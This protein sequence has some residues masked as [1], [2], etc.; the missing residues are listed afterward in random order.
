MNGMFD[1]MHQKARSMVR[2]IQATIFRSFP[3]L[4]LVLTVSSC[5]Q[6]EN[7]PGVEFMPDMYRSPAIEAYMDYHFPD[8][9]MAMHPPE[10]TVPFNPEYMGSAYNPNLPYP[11]PNTTDGYE[12]AGKELRNPIPLTTENL[13]KGEQIFTNYCEHCH[14]EKGEG[15]GAVVENGGHAPPPSF[16]G[17]LSDLPDGKAFH[18]ITYGKG[19]MG[20]HAAQLN[21]KERWLVIHYINDLQN[22]S[23]KL[24]K[25]GKADTASAK[26]DTV[27]AMDTTQQAAMDSGE[28]MK[29]AGTDTGN[30][31]EGTDK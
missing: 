22:G 16:T 25:E 21:K 1:R 17:P 5:H 27:A 30:S 7:S 29:A 11:Y 2:A 3:L 13:E 4:A 20:S 14:G 26:T 6:N 31:N 18:S 28:A 19:L 9:L 12:K 24:L 8:S 15:N 10:G 23:E